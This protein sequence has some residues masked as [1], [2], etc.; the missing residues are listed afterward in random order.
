MS[1]TMK[2]TRRRQRVGYGAYCF[3]AE[4]RAEIIQRWR[5]GMSYRKLAAAY[6]CSQ[7][8]IRNIVITSAQRRTT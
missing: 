3:S 2:A 8:T 7:T 4:Q 1:T 5:D 6:Y